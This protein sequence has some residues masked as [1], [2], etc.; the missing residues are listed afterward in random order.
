MYNSQRQDPSS[1]G[2]CDPVKNLTNGTAR[3][4]FN[5]QEKLDEHKAPD[6]PSIQAQ[7]PV[8][9]GERQTQVTGSCGTDYKPQN[10][11]WEHGPGDGK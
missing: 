11:L 7:E 6:A 3:G 1:A 2:A 10:T 9:T 4:L 8:L 5:S